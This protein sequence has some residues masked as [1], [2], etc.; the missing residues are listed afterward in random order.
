MCWWKHTFALGSLV[1]GAGFC[2]AAGSGLDFV[3]RFFG[4]SVSLLSL[5]SL[6]RFPVFGA[7]VSTG[8]SAVSVGVVL[9]WLLVTRAMS[10]DQFSVQSLR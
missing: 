10:F 1:V 6:T 3:L 8:A 5:A 2:F 4:G 9:A 7:L